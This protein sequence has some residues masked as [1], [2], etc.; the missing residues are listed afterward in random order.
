MRARQKNSVPWDNHLHLQM[1][2]K[3]ARGQVKS[4]QYIDNIWSGKILV[5]NT[6]HWQSKSKGQSDMKEEKKENDIHE[7]ERISEKKI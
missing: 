7:E 2:L 5:I 1:L 4:S 3:D 6:F